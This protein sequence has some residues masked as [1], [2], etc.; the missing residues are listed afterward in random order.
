VNAI[1]NRVPMSLDDKP[2]TGELTGSYGT[3]A[4]SWQ[5]SALTDIA[6]G[7]VALHA[8]GFS[9]ETGDYDT[10]L[11]TQQNSFFRGHG[12][13]LGGSYFLGG[14]DSHVGVAV[15]QYDAR[16]GIPSDTTYINMKQTKV[17][18][19]SSFDLGSGLLKTLN[20]D[21][22]Y[23]DY[24]H[25]ENEP[26]GTTDTTFMNKEYDGRAELL[27]KKIGFVENTALGVEYQH[28]DFSAIGQDGSYLFPATTQSIAGYLFT[29]TQIARR[30]HLEASGRIEHVEV[31]GTPAS[32]IFTKNSYTPLSGAIG[33]L[34]D[35]GKVV[36]LGVTFSST[37]RAPAMT[38]LF[39]RGGHDG[40]NTFETGDPNLKIERANSLEG[41][42]RIRSGRFSFDGSIYS[43]WFKNYIY[44]DLTGRM[45]D[46]DGV[47]A[48]G[49][50]GDLKELNYRQQGAHFRGLEGEAHYQLIKTDHGA[51][52][53]KALA[54][55]TR[56]T[57]DDG[58]NVPRIPPYRIGGGMAW[59]GDTLDA[60]MTLTYVG[61]QND[62][63]LFDTPTPGYV[64]LNE[65]VAWRPFK[66]YPGVEFAIVGQNLTNDVQRNAS[67][68]NKDDV[69]M[70]GRNIRFIVKVATF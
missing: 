22:S 16:Y 60:G 51:F 64:S 12:A 32:N 68:L 4:N 67:S 33:A 26:D 42:L 17:M 14:G 43:S 25:T 35:A 59:Q 21:G 57:L 69:V 45:C 11:G 62:Y 66:Q 56:A 63:G 18:T 30:L 54:D 37:G 58:N 29:D 52:E 47:C 48:F 6:L 8:D 50:D 27:L 20:I 7:N 28:R 19:R 9:R 49:G 46:D 55:Y 53:V 34:Y 38:E 39:A 44:G 1:N 5:G 15:T 41:S 61:R 23:A 31:Q 2:V 10:P 36:K 13:S 70:P 65:Q 3:V 40:P 24:S